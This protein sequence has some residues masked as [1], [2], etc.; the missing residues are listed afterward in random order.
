MTLAP[1]TS[2]ISRGAEPSASITQI[3]ERLPRVE[4]KVRKRSQIWVMDA[5]G[6]APRLMADVPGASV[7]PHWS[8]VGR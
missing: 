8:P 1:G 3:W 2:A 7:T 6:S 5:D 4:E